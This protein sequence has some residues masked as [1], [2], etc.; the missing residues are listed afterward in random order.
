[1][2][3]CGSST[4]IL[5]GPTRLHD[6]IYCLIC[7]QLGQAEIVRGLQINPQLCI[8]TA[9]PIYRWP[10]SGGSI[11]AEA[12]YNGYHLALAFGNGSCKGLFC[13]DVEC[14]ALVP[15]QACSHHHGNSWHGCIHDGRQGRLGHLSYRKHYI[16]VTCASWIK[17]G[18]STRPLR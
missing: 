14:R 9:Q 11:E 6:P 17:V 15:G 5:S 16:N 3:W 18:V 10:A 7:R 13:A 8:R 4:G 1:V 12:Y 2:I